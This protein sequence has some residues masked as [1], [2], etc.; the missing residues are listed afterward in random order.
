MY[1]IHKFFLL[2]I[3]L[4]LPLGSVFALKQEDRITQGG[5]DFY[6]EGYIIHL[7]IINQKLQLLFL[8]KDR[9]VISP[10]YTKGSL[11]V[12]YKRQRTTNEGSI[13]IP[14]QLQ[15]NLYLESVRDLRS[16]YY[17][18]VNITLEDNSGKKIYLPRTSITPQITP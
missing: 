11:R 17:F 13:F 3:A 4:T 5:Y 14:L 16:P 2:A 6:Q 18:F 15:N 7:R 1:L 12:D 10:L 8:N 9:E